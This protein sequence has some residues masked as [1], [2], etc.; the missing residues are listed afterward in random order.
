MS[1]LI[2]LM[3]AGLIVYLVLAGMFILA[4]WGT[5]FRAKWLG[6]AALAAGAPG[7][8]WMGWFAEKFDSGQC[9]SEVIHTISNAV[10]RADDSPRALAAKIRK[11]PVHGYETVCSEVEAA[12]H[13]LPHAAP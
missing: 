1:G 2:L 9:Y 4:A 11:L 5:S 6:L 10:E 12:A 7:F 8:V 3:I 13:A